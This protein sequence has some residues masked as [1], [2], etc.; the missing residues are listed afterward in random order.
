MRSITARLPSRNTTGG[1]IWSVARP[2]TTRVRVP[3]ATWT[4]RWR[5]TSSMMYCGDPEASTTRCPERRCLRICRTAPVG[6][7]L[8]LVGAQT[9]LAARAHLDH[10]LLG[11]PVPGVLVDDARD[12]GAHVRP[13]DLLAVEIPGE[14]RAGVA[15]EERVVD[16]EDGGGATE[17]DH[18]TR[19]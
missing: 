18:A 9:L 8:E 1:T 16:V 4:R 15:V 7:R 12:L 11:E 2:S 13:H 5:P 6:M 17:G 14:D 19:L 3:T 10:V